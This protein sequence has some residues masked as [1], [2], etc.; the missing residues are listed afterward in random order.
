MDHTTENSLSLGTNQT[1][2][3]RFELGIGLGAAERADFERVPRRASIMRAR[4]RA[5]ACDASD[6][7]LKVLIWAVIRVQ[8]GGR[9]IAWGALGCLTALGALFFYLLFLP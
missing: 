4:R 9:K 5:S 6:E 8:G 1:G 2:H 3:R 7:T